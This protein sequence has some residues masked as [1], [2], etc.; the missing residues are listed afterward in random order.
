MRQKKKPPLLISITSTTSKG[1][2][3]AKVRVNDEIF[4][5][6]VAVKEA[7]QGLFFA[8][9]EDKLYDFFHDNV[10]CRTNVLK[11]SLKIHSGEAIR[12]PFI[13]DQNSL[14]W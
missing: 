1:S 2:Y 10:D 14:K 7:H 6:T 9:G 5:F 4:E 11:A 13:L 12:F 8:T 3:I